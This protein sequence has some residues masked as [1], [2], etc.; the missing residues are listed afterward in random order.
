[1]LEEAKAA[2]TP[3]NLNFDRYSECY[4]D[5]ENLESTD[6]SLMT[7]GINTNLQETTVAAGQVRPLSTSTFPGET[8]GLVELPP[9]A[10]T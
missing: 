3:S 10:L 4:D 2:P 1:M 9:S 8:A 7:E 5:R 6:Q